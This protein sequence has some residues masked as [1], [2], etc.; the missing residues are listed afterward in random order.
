M[1]AVPTLVVNGDLDAIAP[2]ADGQ[3]VART[4]PGARF[5]VVPNVGHVPEY[6]ETGCVSRLI[7]TF[8]RTRKVVTRRCLRHLPA[9]PVR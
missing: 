6:D 3:A 8:M 9:V 1:P 2:P 4:I 5:I 7:W